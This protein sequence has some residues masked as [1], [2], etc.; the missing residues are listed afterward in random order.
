MGVK[1]TKCEIYGSTKQYVSVKL[2][3]FKPIK[4]NKIF[5]F[6]AVKTFKNECGPD[7]SISNKILTSVTD[8]ELAVTVKARRLYCNF[9]FQ[10]GSRS[11]D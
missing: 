3:Q 5:P 6:R 7:R 1:F 10:H 4:Y 9:K 8:N 2:Q 11:Y